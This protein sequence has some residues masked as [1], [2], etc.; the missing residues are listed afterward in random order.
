MQEKPNGPARRTKV[1]KKGYSGVYFRDTA[2]GRRYEITYLDSDGRRRWQTVQGFDNLDEANAVLG[3]LT[4]RLRKGERVAPTRLKFAELYE[5]WRTQ[6]RLS[7]RTL[8]HY[9]RNMRLY[10]LPRFGRRKAQDVSV[11]DVAR[12][13]AELE[14]QGLANWTI[15]GVLTALSAMYA[16]AVRRGRLSVN[17]VRGL[18]RGERPPAEGRDKRIL[19]RDEI[20]RL[21]EAAPAPYRTLLATGV[22]SGLRLQELLGLRWQDVDHEIGELHVRYQL[23]RKGSTLKPLKSKAGKRDVALMPELAA[24]LRR[25]QFASRHTRPDDFVFAGA[26]GRPLHFSNVQKR[27][28]GK[29]VEL[30]GFNGGKRAP[31]MH[32]LRHTFASLL[33]AQGLDVVFV[34]RQLGHANPATTLRVYASE[35]DRA[36]NADAARSALSAGFG[37]VL[38]TA[39]RNHRQQP[40]LETAQISQIRA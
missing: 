37:N 2:D 23:T 30:A 11:D 29:A 20:G 19:S 12:L 34:S 22:F 35:F 3:E 36:R 21:L 14:R 25:H 4:Q 8:D 15:R 32:D 33:I 38:E 16:W 1:V 39:T 26:A 17:P 13:I 28:M 31:T 10:L 5:E 27:G 9:E 24:L 6:L 40:K 18:E 7:E